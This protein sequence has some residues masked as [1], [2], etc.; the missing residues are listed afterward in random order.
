MHEHEPPQA[1]VEP[2]APVSA[3]GPAV[4]P[5]GLAGMPAVALALQRTIGNRL[6]S[7]ALA[8]L[9]REEAV[10]E[11]GDSI[12]LDDT[13]PPAAAA[14]TPTF[15][16]S[17][18][19]TVTIDAD[20]AVDFS[21]KIVST[22]GAPH[23]KPQFVPEIDFDFKTDANEKEIPGTR[24]VKSVGLTVKTAITKVRFGMGRVD[25]DNR[26]MIGQMVQEIQAHEERHRKIV[27]DA[28]TAALAAAQKFV[29]T[30]KV[31]EARK[32]LSTTLECTTNGQHE[33]L[34]ASEGLLTVS[35]VRQP[36]GTITLTLTKSGSGAK[37]P[38]KK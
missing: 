13:A 36:N 20:S 14:P 1:T 27:E 21:S 7:R 16:H 12:P 34:D 6:V 18:G 15:D 32:A 30:K 25:A 24:T 37:Y 31:D 10:D 19:S 2:A 17:G 28:A 29:G 35:E 11:I 3:P 26:A 38:C 33:A 5:A 23:V 22:I 8:Q 9:A 4:V